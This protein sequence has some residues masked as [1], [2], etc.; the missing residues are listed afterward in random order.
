[1]KKI[2]ITGFLAI[3]LFVVVGCSNS[4]KVIELNLSN[5]EE[6]IENLNDGEFSL[7]MVNTDIMTEYSETLTYIYDFEYEDYFNLDS[8]NVDGNN[9]VVK[10]NKE[11]KELLAIISATDEEDVLSSMKDFCDDLNCSITDFEEYIIIVSSSDNDSV[12]EKIKNTTTP[13]FNEM[14][15]VDA[16]FLESLTKIKESDLE[17]YLVKVPMMMT[18]SATY[19]ILKPTE[20][21]Y[22]SVKNLMDD[23]MDSLEETWEMYLPDQY[24]LVKNRL[25]VSYGD[26]L[27]YIISSDNDLVLET[28]KG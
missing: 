15:D 2:M 5:I 11:T 19:F 28:I 12:I 4:D 1:M 26:Y 18:S 23:Y 16:E 13:V 6:N 14:M 25:E 17:E 3:S 8:N 21:A 24:D 20:E 27:I 22:D 7:T 10:Y 9:S